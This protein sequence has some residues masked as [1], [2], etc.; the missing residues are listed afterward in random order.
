MHMGG[1]LVFLEVVQRGV[2]ILDSGYIIILLAVSQKDDYPR[3]PSSNQVGFDPN[4]KIVSSLHHP[5]LGHQNH[6]QS[7][8]PQLLLNQQ[9]TWPT[10]P[11]QHPYPSKATSFQED[12]CSWLE[13]RRQHCGKYL[14]RATSRYELQWIFLAD[15]ELR[16]RM[17]AGG[18]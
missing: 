2:L 14:G 6:F 15:L 17:I 16:E 8:R 1:C 18:L 13:S 9:S 11:F 4:Y 10:F 3:L 7:F 12:F 5:F